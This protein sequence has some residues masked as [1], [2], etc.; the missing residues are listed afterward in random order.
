MKS[1]FFLLKFILIQTSKFQIENFYYPNIY[2][3]KTIWTMILEISQ[4]VNSIKEKYFAMDSAINTLENFERLIVKNYVIYHDAFDEYCSNTGPSFRRKLI[5]CLFLISS[6]VIVINFVWHTKHNDDVSLKF[7][8]FPLFIPVEARKPVFAFILLIFM[9][10]NITKLVLLYY[11]RK[12]KLYLI[13]MINSWIIFRSFDLKP[14]KSFKLDKLINFLFGVSYI[15][16]TMIKLALFLIITLNSIIGYLYHDYFIFKLVLNDLYYMIMLQH[17]NHIFLLMIFVV[18]V[19]IVYFNYKFE[20]ILKTLRVA[21][22]WNNTRG[23]MNAIAAHH[24]TTD[25]I[26]KLS[27]A[28]NIIIGTLYMIVPYVLVLMLKAQ[29][30]PGLPLYIRA[31]IIAMFIITSIII[32]LFN[33][34]CASVTVKNNRAPLQLYRVYCSYKYI[35]LQFRLKILLIL[36]KLTGDFVGFYCLNLYKFT[37]ITYYTYFITLFTTYILVSKLLK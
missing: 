18:F 34:L 22:R 27:Y 24:S 17:V 5:Y 13:N 33:I 36:E 26:H 12:R 9:I 8:G 6:F 21:I 1:L 30:T 4:I 2:T 3:I 35:N 32:H 11:E 10:I 15:I 31:I 14:D 7:T 37:K 28:Y 23:I 29:L 19:T 20:E 16:F 25:L